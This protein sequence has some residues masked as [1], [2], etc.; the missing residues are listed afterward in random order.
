MSKRLSVFWLAAGLTAHRLAAVLAGMAAVQT[1]AFTAAMYR[2]G[3]YSLK[4]IFSASRISLIC[5]A[6]FVLYCAAICFRTSGGKNRKSHYVLNR[7]SVPEKAIFFW[8]TVYHTMC[9]FIFWG[10]QVLLI[11]LF[12]RMFEMHSGT[13][14]RGAQTVFITVYEDPFLRGMLPLDHIPQHISNLVL[15]FALGCSTASVSM[16]TT[17]KNMV[18][19]IVMLVVWTLLW[20]ARSD[21][22]GWATILAVS[23]MSIIVIL[24]RM[25]VIGGVWNEEIRG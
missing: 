1:A 3:D 24:V 12:C 13:G 22:T 6:A 18:N 20:F 9:F 5:A 16:G 15:I 21:N 23:A 2:F 10:V 11:F 8:W 7:L 14:I 19:T 4:Q 25:L 17:K